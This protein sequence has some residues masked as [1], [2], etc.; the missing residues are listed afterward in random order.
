LF[1]SESNSYFFFEQFVLSKTYQPLE[2]NIL[3]IFVIIKYLN[4]HYFIIYFFFD[5][6]NPTSLSSLFQ[7]NRPGMCRMH[8]TGCRTAGAHRETLIF[9]INNPIFFAIYTHSVIVLYHLPKVLKY[10]HFNYLTKYIY[11]SFN[12]TFVSDKS[13]KFVKYQ[14]CPLSL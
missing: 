14:I 5:I 7:T 10:F 4:C 8:L 3:I 2:L 6:S 13:F 9:F 12:F 1:S 11:K